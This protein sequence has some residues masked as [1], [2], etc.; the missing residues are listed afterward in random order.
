M[1]RSCRVG[2]V[3]DQRRNS[4]AI[5]GGHPRTRRNGDGSEEMDLL[6]QRASSSDDAGIRSD[7]G[8]EFS[9]RPAGDLPVAPVE[10]GRLSRSARK[11]GS[12]GGQ[13]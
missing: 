8:L 12:Q 5:A 2:T 6:D 4:L 3:H 13:R 10:P 7:E 11:I 1:V 9:W